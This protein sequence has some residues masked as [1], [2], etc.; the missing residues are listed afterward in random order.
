MTGTC[1]NITN[2]ERLR[3]VT[4]YGLVE[5]N[6]LFPR[7]VLSPCSMSK[8]RGKQQRLPSS[9]FL[10]AGLILTLMK[11]AVGSSE[12]SENLYRN[13]LKKT[14]H[15]K[16][17]SYDKYQVEILAFRRRHVCGLCDY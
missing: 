17:Q 2:F 7:T 10:I 3:D 16:R 14:E 13:T 5:I 1:V 15:F 9:T 4:P 6:P 8:C 12:T 11:E